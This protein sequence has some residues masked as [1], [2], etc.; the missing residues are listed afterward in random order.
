MLW[1]NAIDVEIEINFYSNLHR[2][3]LK[4]CDVTFWTIPKLNKIW[5]VNQAE[6]LTFELCDNKQNKIGVSRQSIYTLNV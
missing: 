5:A 4:L 2:I 6:T 1:L 3:E